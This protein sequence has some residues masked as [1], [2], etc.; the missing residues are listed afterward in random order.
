MIIQLSQSKCYVLRL[1]EI[2]GSI[3]IG[4]YKGTFFISHIGSFFAWFSFNSQ[5]KLF[6]PIMGGLQLISNNL[7][8][9]NINNDIDDL[10]V[11]F[12]HILIIKIMLN[13]YKKRHNILISQ[14]LISYLSIASTNPFWITDNPYGV[15]KGHLHH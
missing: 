15:F 11:S 10:S 1:K 6:S 13:M 2:L 14:H 5:T 3:P 8:Y 4:G 9:S 7:Q 12:Y